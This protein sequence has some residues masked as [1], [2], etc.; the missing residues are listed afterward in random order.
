MRVFIPLAVF[1][2]KVMPLVAFF[3]S[4]FPFSTS[5]LKSS[6]SGSHSR[7]QS[8]DLP[9]RASKQREK[10]FALF[11]T[12]H[13]EPSSSPF[14]SNFLSLQVNAFQPKAIDWDHAS[15]L[16][17]AKRSSFDNKD[18]GSS[19]F[20]EQ[21]SE[22]L[23]NFALTLSDHFA[24]KGTIPFNVMNAIL[25]LSILRH[26]ILPNVIPISRSICNATTGE[27]GTIVVVG[28]T[29]GQFLD[30][31][32][33]IK[34]DLGG[35]PS[36]DIRYIINGDIVDRGDMAVEILAVLL[37][38][39]LACDT[40]VTIVRG[41]HETTLMNSRHGFAGEVRTKFGREKAR[42]EKFRAFF[43]TLP[44]AAVIEDSIFVVHGGIGE[45][46]YNMTIDELNKIE[47]NSEDNLDNVQTELLWS[48]K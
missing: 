17:D 28:D 6:H 9:M 12:M 13:H 43:D 34:K 31:H 45:M 29:H 39:K 7:A 10:T 44:M 23:K 25:D 38:F 8:D 18:M 1:A 4:G 26:K 32:Q 21:H 47:M 22:E 11:D 19:L 3:G 41:N 37:T 5:I 2:I 24:S 16:L 20:T 15:K 33:I 30:F 48:G 36:N 42:L 40:S 46:T 35:T 27:R 14:A